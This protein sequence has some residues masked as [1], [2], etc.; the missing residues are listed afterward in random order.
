MSSD[1]LVLVCIILAGTL[2]VGVVWQMFCA[3]IDARNERDRI[4]RAEARARRYRNLTD[5][6]NES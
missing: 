6:N 4:R 2:I 1:A 5:R 3:H